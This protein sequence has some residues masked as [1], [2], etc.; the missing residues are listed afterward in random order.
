MNITATLLAQSAV[1]LIFVWFCHRFIWPFLRQAMRERQETIAEGL[2]AAERAQQDLEAAQDRAEA[3]L[4]EAREEARQIV[5]QARGQAAQ[6]I[7]QARA[8]AREE[9]E[10]LKQAA[11][12]EME[13]DANRVKEA[14]RAQVAALAVQG[15]E[16]ILSASIDR[17]RHSEL[18]DR[19]AG[20]L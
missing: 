11:A 1:F 14:L 10:R 18:L 8:E 19:L 17:R 12:A 6:M 9:G 16:R 13:Q 4:S 15:A 20:E 2:E 3:R 7:E 5:D